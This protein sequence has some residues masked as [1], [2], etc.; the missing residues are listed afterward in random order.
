M[1]AL[2]HGP[3]PAIAIGVTRG[4]SLDRVTEPVPGNARGALGAVPAAAGVA[5][6]AAPVAPQVG[7]DFVEAAL[8]L[9]ADMT[10]RRGGLA[11]SSRAFH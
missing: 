10:P 1:R 9:L 4:G 11:A 3:R 6:S 2:A 7:L 5:T 8:G